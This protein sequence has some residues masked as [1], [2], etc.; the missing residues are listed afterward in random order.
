MPL[1]SLATGWLPAVLALFSVRE[2]SL[3]ASPAYRVPDPLI[4]QTVEGLD[5]FPAAGVVVFAAAPPAG[6][7]TGLSGTDGKRWVRISTALTLPASATDGARS[8]FFVITR[9]SS[10]RFMLAAGLSRILRKRS[11]PGDTFITVPTVRP[12]GNIW[13]PPLVT[14]RSPGPTDSSVITFSRISSP[15]ELPLTT[16]AGATGQELRQCRCSGR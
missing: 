4:R 9:T 1:T 14:T 12:L 5:A 15:L 10:N 8:S 3:V 7:T 11:A 6:S 2:P 13:S 16:S